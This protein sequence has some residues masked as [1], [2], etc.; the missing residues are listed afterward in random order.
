MRTR[1]LLV[2]E[3]VVLDGGVCLTVLA[4]DGAEVLFGI[5]LPRPVPDEAAPCHDGRFVVALRYCQSP[6]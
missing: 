4:I 3:E 5:T 2:G 6:N 1:A